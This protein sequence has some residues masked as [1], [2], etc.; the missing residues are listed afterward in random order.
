[1]NGVLSL[2]SRDFEFHPTGT[3]ELTDRPR[4]DGHDGMREYF[5][6]VARV[7][8]ELRLVPQRFEEVDARLLVLGRVYGQTIDGALVDSP[9]GWIWEAEGGKLTRCI[10]YRS[11]DEALAA[12]GLSEE[13]AHSGS[14]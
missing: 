14:Q 10:V 1:V 4:Y 9:A 11:H 5:N 3:A 6:D 13:E 8:T 7:W 2:I 12:S